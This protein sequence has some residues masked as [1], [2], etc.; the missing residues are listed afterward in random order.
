MRVLLQAAQFYRNQLKDAPHA[1]E[2]L[3][4]R[5][6]S[7]EIAKH[8]GIGYAPDGWQNLEQVFPDYANKV[9]ECCGTGQA[10][11]GWPAL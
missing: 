9:A 7:G 2:Y 5:G 4:R 3:K 6:L 10:K 8:F 1:I 11:R